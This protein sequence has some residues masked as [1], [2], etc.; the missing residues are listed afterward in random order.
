MC[1]YY[2]VFA[3]VF[4]WLLKYSCRIQPNLS[5]HAVAVPVAVVVSVTDDFIPDEGDA[6]AT[7][8]SS[9]NGWAPVSPI[10]GGAAAAAAI[11]AVVFAF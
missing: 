9:A 8:D 11:L 2:V 4:G 5:R 3:A 7:D 1:V 6:D 10:S